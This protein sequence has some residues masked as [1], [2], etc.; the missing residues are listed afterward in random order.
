[1]WPSMTEVT[2]VCSNRARVALESEF[3]TEDF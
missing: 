3:L 2:C 1:L